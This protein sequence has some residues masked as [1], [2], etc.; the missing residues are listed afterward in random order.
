LSYPAVVT[1]GN[2]TIS[3]GHVVEN[4]VINGIEVFKVDTANP[5][6]ALASIS[7]ISNDVLD[8]V[9]IPT[10][11]VG[12]DPNESISYYISGQPEGI[13]IDVSTGQISG[14]ISSNALTGGANGNGVHTV[15][16]SVLKPNSA[17]SSQVFTWTMNAGPLFW[18][19]YDEDE[20]YTARHENSFV[21]AGD[22]FYL[23][24]G[25]ESATT[26]DVYDYTSDSWNS[27]VNSA[28]FE[29]N[30]FQATE[31]QGLIWVIGSFKDN[32]FPTETP[33]EFV[34][35]FDPANE[36]WIQGPQIPVNR[37]RGSAGL[38]MYNNKFYV[39]AGNTLGHNGGF[40]PHFDEFDPATGVW[41][42][43]TDAPRARDHF[44]AVVIGNELYVSGGRLS[45]GAGGTFGPTI[46]EVDVYD[47]INQTWSTLP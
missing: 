38:V 43:L 25:R 29:F 17:P 39:V 10:N 24:G 34:W 23:M 36:E 18:T 44:A 5:V 31:Y 16:V 21:Q 8:V 33:A 42:T 13:T 1:D 28:P 4:P 26:I 37:R 46:Q 35:A 41:T 22:K 14:T 11:A 30:H 6:L 47:F 9:S 40:V 2:L 7:N 3:F 45:G 20:N 32:A 27:L 12:G 15:T 19:D